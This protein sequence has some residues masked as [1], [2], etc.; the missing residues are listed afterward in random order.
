MEL[1]PGPTYPEGWFCQNH[2]RGAF[3]SS[4]KA[5]ASKGSGLSMLDVNSGILSL[6]IYLYIPDCIRV[7]AFGENRFLYI[8]FTVVLTPGVI[9]E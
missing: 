1:S 3:E 5:P 8:V 9:E 7:E 2:F 4:P 6:G